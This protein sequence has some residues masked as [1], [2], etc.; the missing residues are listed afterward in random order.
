M[1]KQAILKQMTW[2][3]KATLL[4]GHRNWWFNGIER[5]GIRKFVVGDGPHGLRAYENLSEQGGY[6]NKRLP[7]TAFPC[8]S[9]MASTWN[10]ALLMS[11]GETIGKECNQ[12]QVDVLLAPGVVGKRSPLCGRNFEY[13]SEDPLLAGKMGAAFVKGVQSQG[14]GTSVKHFA[15]NEQETARRFISSDVEERTFRELYGQTFEIIVKEAKPLT[16]MSSYNRIN[17][18]YASEN[19]KLL[20]DLLRDEW[21]YKGIV[22]SDWGAVQDKR[23]SVLAG[24]DIE[25]PESEWKNRFV[26]EVVEGK[27]PSKVIDATV[28]RILT[29][30]E[31]LLANPNRGKPTNLDENHLVARRVAEESIVLLK[32]EGGILPLNPKSNTVV[33][34]VFAEQPRTNGGGSSELRA[35]KIENP[36]AE[37][38]LYSNVSHFG[39]YEMTD[40]L[41]NALK[42]ANQVVIFTGTT[43]D[44]EGEGFDRPHMRLPQEQIQFV[45]E[46]AKL[47]SNMILVNSSGSAI[48]THPFLGKV[49]AFIQSWF[50]GSAAGTPIADILFGKVNPSGKLS[51]TFPIKLENT[52]VYPYY[53]GKG[54][55]TIYSEGLFTGYRQFDTYELPVAFPFGFGLSYTTFEYRNLIVDKAAMRAGETVTLSVDVVNTGKFAGKEIIQIYIGKPDSEYPQPKKVLRKYQK[56][57]LAVGQTKTILF[58]LQ[59]R[60]FATFIPQ[61]DRFLTEAGNY[62]IF[63]AASVADIRFTHQIRIDSADLTRLPIGFEHPVR[64]WLEREPEKSKMEAFFQQYRKLGHWEHEDPVRRVG[65][66]IAIEKGFDAT[67][68]AKMFDFLRD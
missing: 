26:Q 58:E 66:R 3:E 67:E 38:R 41:K 9:A 27:Y 52:S 28:L 49:K 54:E 60:D 7:A 35:Y 48:E 64:V 43:P 63:V 39:P 33:C 50:L 16:I 47:H 37:I 32:N 46:V 56:V 61:A 42:T 65:N 51:E 8:A 40:A 19:P 1:D 12:Y 21:G 17:G 2:E 29:V 5:L 4:T 59:G 34:G 62:Q 13:Y 18:V 36:L 30:Y 11:V 24:L 25:M 23:S 53:P 57:S 15:L 14:V 20:R 10:D 45:N 44:L 31:K 6:P 22:I 55:K 68:T